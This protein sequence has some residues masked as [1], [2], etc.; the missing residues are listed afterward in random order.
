MRTFSPAS[1]AE[2]L[3]LRASEGTVPFA[4]GTD[5]MVRHRAKHGLPPTVPGPVMF[6]NALPELRRVRFADGGDLEI[7]ASVSM[8]V[9]ADDPGER[10]AC[11]TSGAALPEALDAVPEL[12][13][14]AAASLGA[15]GL[16]NRATLA[17]NTA[18]ASPAGDGVIALYALDA[19][20]VLAS[21]RGERE[22]PVAEFITGPGRTVLSGDEIIVGFRVPAAGRETTA[23]PETGPA[24]GPR[25]GLA[26]GTGSLPRPGTEETFWHYWRKVGTRRAN[27]LTKVSLA[28]FARTAG[29]RV[30]S[31]AL[32]FGA[33]GPTVV[34]VP[35]AEALFAGRAA[36]DIL[37]DTEGIVRRASGIMSPLIRPIDDQRST[38]AYRKTVAM[39]LAA[40]AL[41]RFAAH[42][43]ETN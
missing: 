4:G 23:A 40:L 7:G 38:A 20:V 17:G 34:R 6:V 27:A 29:G 1:L 22:M 2:A 13:R 30:V 36:E 25:K 42:L 41:E 3:E 14:E 12:L 39:N 31:F 43:K 24:G 26:V 18:N 10:A 37:A 21:V 16:R 9:L 11:A 5:L 35:E 33:V 19:R 32:A 28:A 15:P 8:A